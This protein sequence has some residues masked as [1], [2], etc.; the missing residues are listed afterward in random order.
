MDN[1]DLAK[2]PMDS[3]NDEKTLVDNVDRTKSFV[4]CQDSRKPIVDSYNIVCRT[5]ADR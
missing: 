2:T 3:H 4:D 5:L 1:V